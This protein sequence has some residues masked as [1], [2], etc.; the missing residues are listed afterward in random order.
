MLGKPNVESNGIE[1]EE[2]KSANLDVGLI[3][4]Q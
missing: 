1:I 4:A 2:L 3:Q